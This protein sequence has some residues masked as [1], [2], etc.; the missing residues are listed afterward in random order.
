M[1]PSVLT[2]AK[3]E[4]SRLVEPRRFV[5]RDAQSFAAIWA[6]HAGPDAP[7]PAIDFDTRMV[8]AVFAGERP[9]PGFAVTI[10]GTRRDP[11]ALVVVVD[12]TQPDPS[13]MMAQVMSS[14]YHVASLPRDDGDIRFNTPDPTGQGTIVFKPQKR[15][16]PGLKKMDSASATAA[17]VGTPRTNAPLAD[18]SSL[19]AT[20]L[21]PETA[22]TMAYLAGPFSGALLLAS[23]PHNR[24]VRFHAWQSVLG[25]GVLGIAAITFLLLAFALL[26]VSPLAFWTML[27]LAAITGLAWIAAW[28]ICVVQA[29]KGRVWK[30][31]LAGGYAERKA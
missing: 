10:T 3:G 31:P 30:L 19:S 20:G 16:L 7:P 24:F 21:K 11:D 29:Y 6:A 28:G 13:L 14:P 22:A 8:A 23:E 2:I 1:E 25:L 5:I 17:P 15:Q 27:W 4:D 9:T 12:E 18:R 26:I